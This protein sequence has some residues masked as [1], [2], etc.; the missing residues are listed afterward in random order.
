MFIVASVLTM[1]AATGQLE[2]QILMLIELGRKDLLPSYFAG[3]LAVVIG[4]TAVSLLAY[5]CRTI[6]GTIRI[7]PNQQSVRAEDK[8][9]A[10]GETTV[11]RWALL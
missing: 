10:V 2:L 3:L 8:A 1:W 4:L 9:L 5:G 7:Q 6:I 11:K